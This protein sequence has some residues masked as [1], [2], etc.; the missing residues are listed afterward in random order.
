MHRS[1][2]MLFGKTETLGSTSAQG[3]LHHGNQGLKDVFKS[4]RKEGVRCMEGQVELIEK[5]NKKYSFCSFIQ[6]HQ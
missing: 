2:M 1:S 5:A 6:R 4:G 3:K